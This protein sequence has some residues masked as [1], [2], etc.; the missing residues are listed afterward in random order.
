MEYCLNALDKVLSGMGAKIK[1]GVAV[2][3]A[4]AAFEQSKKASLSSADP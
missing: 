4:K 3:A 1:S 2:T